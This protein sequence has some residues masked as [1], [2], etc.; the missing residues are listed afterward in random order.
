MESELKKEVVTQVRSTINISNEARESTN[1]EHSHDVY[2]END[3]R[4]E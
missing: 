3:F 1:T 4:K 2:A